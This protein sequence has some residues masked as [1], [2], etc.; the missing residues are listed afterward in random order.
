MLLNK[1]KG[2][3]GAFRANGARRCSGAGQHA[4]PHAQDDEEMDREQET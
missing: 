3:A 1:L 2:R 4:A